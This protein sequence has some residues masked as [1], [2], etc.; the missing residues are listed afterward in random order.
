M[1]V[2]I[3][4]LLLI[5]ITINIFLT[6]SP[7]FRNILIFFA[8]CDIIMILVGI[9]KMNQKSRRKQAEENEQIEQYRKLQKEGIKAEAV[10]ENIQAIYSTGKGLYIM[11]DIDVVIEKPEGTTFNACIKKLIS[12]LEIPQYQPGKRVYVKY[13]PSDPTGLN[14]ILDK[15]L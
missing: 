15:E 13:H 8:V 9:K 14:E 11:S 12:Q 2:F 10:I 7:L 5:P 1:L 3:G 6:D 4:L